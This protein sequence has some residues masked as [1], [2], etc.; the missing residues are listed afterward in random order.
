VQGIVWIP[1]VGFKLVGTQVEGQI[2]LARGLLRTAKPGY[3]PRVIHQG[4]EAA[5]S[6]ALGFAEMGDTKQIAS[7]KAE[8]VYPGP[9]INRLGP[10]S[11]S[12]AHDFGH[13]PGG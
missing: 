5:K 2:I 10:R 13:H 4:P 8:D 3:L 9:K 11:S 1:G 12:G 7:I 6:P